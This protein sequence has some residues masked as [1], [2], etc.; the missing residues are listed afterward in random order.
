MQQRPKDRQG[1]FQATSFWLPCLLVALGG[2]I[3]VAAADSPRFVRGDANMSGWV[4]YVDVTF[5]LGVIYETLDAEFLCKDAAD[6]DDNGFVNIQD[7]ILVLNY[8][9]KDQP[10]PPPPFPEL[11]PDPTADGLDC[12]SDLITGL[13]LDPDFTIAW[14]ND[15]QILRGR[16]EVEFFLLATT[17]G[18]VECIS[19]VYRVDRRVAENVRVDLAGTLFPQEDRTSFEES[20]FFEYRVTPV[21]AQFDRLEVNATFAEQGG[22]AIFGFAATERALDGER[23]LRILLDVPEDAPVGP[24]VF[25]DAIPLEEIAPGQDFTHFC[26]GAAG[27]GAG[28]GAGGTGGAPA[29][30][31]PLAADGSGA[32]VDA[33]EYLRGDGNGDGEIDLSDAVFTL[34]FLFAGEAP[35]DCL[36]SAD[37]NDSGEIDV[38]D[39]IFLLGFLYLGKGE[40][41]QPYPACGTD[42][43]GDSLT[44]WFY[45]ACPAR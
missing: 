5:F 23:L 15:P 32:I 20:E 24:A 3:K 38:S 8:M 31:V 39:P 21:G 17:K 36:K 12:E 13:R 16:S 43:T 9:Y 6:A 28:A 30:V 27:A 40:L 18:P 22:F 42:P 33:E 44:C 25:L 2:G 35:P 11:G 4:T 34:G 45:P 19:I 37:T 26:G 29:E 7:P 10:P 1:R 41:P 14:E